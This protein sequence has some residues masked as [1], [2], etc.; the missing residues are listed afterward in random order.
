MLSETRTPGSKP[1]GMKRAVL[2]VLI[3]V[4]A[5]LASV[6]AAASTAGAAPTGQVAHQW[7]G[8]GGSRLVVVRM[9]DYRLLQPTILPPG[10]YTFRAVNVGRAEHA[11]QING[12]GV[13]NARTPD[14]QSDQ[15]ADLTVNLTRGVYDFWCPV[16]NHRQLGM[17]V[18]VVVG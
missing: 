14:V 4:V 15:Y 7:G 3:G 5:L 11:L 6:C 18:G 9:V 13:A 8:G 17:Q 10:Q 12:P 1:T 2:G 16:G